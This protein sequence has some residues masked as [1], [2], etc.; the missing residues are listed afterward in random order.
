MLD[1]SECVL[2][3]GAIQP[4]LLYRIGRSRKESVRSI[5][6]VV[7]W[8]VNDKFPALSHLRWISSN[9]SGGRAA[10]ACGNGLRTTFWNC[11]KIN[12]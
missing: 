10:T 9:P 11:A 3:L 7:Q 4:S 5:I 12:Q 8:F 1:R 2:Q 6:R